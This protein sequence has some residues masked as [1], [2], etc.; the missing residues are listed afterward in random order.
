MS[1]FLTTALSNVY[2]FGGKDYTA[3][4]EDDIPPTGFADLFYY[5][6]SGGDYFQYFDLADYFTLDGPMVGEYTFLKDNVPA[7]TSFNSANFTGSVSGLPISVY[8]KTTI[9]EKGVSATLGGE[10][11]SDVI[12]VTYEYFENSTPDTPAVT[13]EKWYAKGI[14]LIYY[15]SDFYGGVIQIGRHTV[16]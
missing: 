9:T 12:K 14:G 10:V 8:I 1:S 7:G 11:F 13:E 15:D 4:S 3:F 2:T 6:K 16:L 5:R